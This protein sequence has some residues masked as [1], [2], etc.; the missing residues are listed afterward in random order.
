MKHNIPFF[1]LPLMAAAWLILPGCSITSKEPQD[2]PAAGRVLEYGTLVPI[3]SA[4]VTLYKCEGE[5]LGNFSCTG[6]SSTLSDKDGRYSFSETGFLTNAHKDGY[7]TDNTTEA[8]V[9]FG[10]ED[11]ADIILPPYA[12]LKV[13]IRN[14][15]GAYQIT[16]PGYDMLWGG[17]SFFMSQGLDSTFV[18]FRKGNQDYKYLF[19][20]IPVEGGSSTHDLNAF[21]IHSADG[22]QIIPSLENSAAPWFKVYLPG[23][24][25]TTLTITY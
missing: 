25:T 2:K 8:Q 16:A 24:D 12:W 18:L 19:S 3:D 13:T 6:I 11:K 14:E 22:Q 17:Q 5:V 23:H 1:L 15:S 21:Q 7:F 4:T 10:S 9:L 20:V